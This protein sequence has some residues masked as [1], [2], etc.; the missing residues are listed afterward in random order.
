MAKATNPKGSGRKTNYERMLINKETAEKAV[1]EIFN[2]LEK[3]VDELLRFEYIQKPPRVNFAPATDP[4]TLDNTVQAGEPTATTSPQ[5]AVAK[6]ETSKAVT[7]TPAP[8]TRGVVLIAGGHPYYGQMAAN[9]AASLHLSAPGIKIHLAWHGLALTHLDE[10]KKSLFSSMEKLKEEY[11]MDN[12]K[13]NYFKAKTHLLDITPFTDSLFLDVD[14]MWMPRNP[15]TKLMDELKNIDFTITNRERIDIADIGKKTYLWADINSIK[16]TYGF[17]NGFIYGLH[18][19][20]IWFKKTE[21]VKDYFKTVKEIYNSPKVKTVQ[22]AGGV[23]DEIAFAIAS[24]KHNIYP[25]KFPFAPVYWYLTDNRKGTSL[26]YVDQNYIAYSIGGNGTPQPV[27]ERYNIL[28]NAH[29]KRLGILH[30]WR[31]IPK[32]SWVTERAKL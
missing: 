22:I 27:R 11:V 6:T 13:A 16:T 3:E 5:V 24:V 25:H 1:S 14:M 12:G 7:E 10:K 8:I 28:A 15:V 2:A 26:S 20:L 18:S 4:E 32:R 21:K 31:C 30:P 29:A 17:T 23:P 9:L 19:E